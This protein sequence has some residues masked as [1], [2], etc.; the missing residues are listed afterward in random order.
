VNG[1]FLGFAKVIA[2]HRR[3]ALADRLLR[4]QPEL[5]GR[6]RKRLRR[7]FELDE[8]AEVEGVESDRDAVDQPAGAVLV[9]DELDPVAE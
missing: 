7:P 2:G 9:E 8:E 1:K 6:G 3:I 4:V 5:L